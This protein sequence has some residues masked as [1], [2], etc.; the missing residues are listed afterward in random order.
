MT[1][2]DQLIQYFEKFPGVGARQARRFAAHI[3]NLSK[4][5]SATLSQLIAELPHT[6]TTC[7]HCYRFFTATHEHQTWCDI[8][9]DQNRDRTKVLVVAHDTDITALERSGVYQG[10]Y[11]V[12]G[13]TVPILS[14]PEAR[15]LR[16]NT[17]RESIQQRIQNDQLHE[18]ILGFPVNP[19]GENTE[20]FI[21]NK[22]QNM[23]GAENIRVTHLGRGLSTGSELE[24]ADRDTLKH[25]LVQRTSEA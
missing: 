1:T 13:G 20:R 19:D 23:D 6:V 25:A 12:L 18:V 21:R 9:T 10:L 17:L 16:A 3:M 14:E 2:L 24:Y 8:C 7:H 22:L 11:F 4:E 5:E 15:S